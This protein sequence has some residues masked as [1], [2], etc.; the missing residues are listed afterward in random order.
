MVFEAIRHQLRY[1]AGRQIRNVASAAGN[2]ATA[3]P[4]S[5]LN[6][7]FVASDAI[8]TA[9]S[10]TKGEFELPLTSFFIGYRKTF[11]FVPFVLHFSSYA[12][13]RSL[14]P[15]AVIVRISV[16][17]PAESSTERRIVRS[18][19]QARRKDDDIAIVTAGL[20]ILVD[21]QGL[22]QSSTL[23]YGGMA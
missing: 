9:A 5:D 16:P 15:D 2:L 3:S 7:V 22:I 10:K 1:F 23:A 4:I 19:K 6:P 18:Y 14:P 21:P 12:R 11:V 20:S 17:L 8:I 13:N